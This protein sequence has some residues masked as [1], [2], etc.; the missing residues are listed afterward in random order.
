MHYAM[1]EGD[2]IPEH[3]H[4]DSTLHNIVVLQGEVTLLEGESR[5]RLLAGVMHDFDGRKAHKIICESEHAVI[6]NMFLNGIPHGYSE[7]PESEHQG[8]L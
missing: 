2:E 8:T 6:C 3:A 7:L 4:D 1:E 5:T